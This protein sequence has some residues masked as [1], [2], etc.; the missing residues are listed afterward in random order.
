MNLGLIQIY[1]SDW[2]AHP[3]DHYLLPAY[4]SFRLATAIPSVA[5]LPYPFRWLGNRSSL[6]QRI[7]KGCF[8]PEI[9]ASTGTSQDTPYRLSQYVTAYVLC[10]ISRLFLWYQSERYLTVV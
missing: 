3:A 10:D 8:L 7:Q 4:C 1:V 9:A 5:E 2:F 6:E